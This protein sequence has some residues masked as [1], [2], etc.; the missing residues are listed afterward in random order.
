VVN[1]YNPSTG[2]ASQ[3][4]KVS[5]NLAWTTKQEPAQKERRKESRREREGIKEG[6]KRKRRK[7]IHE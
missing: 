2:E 1:A 6:R 7:E 4:Y 3:G 5:S